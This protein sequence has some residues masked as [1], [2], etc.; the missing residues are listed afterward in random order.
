LKEKVLGVDWERS[1]ADSANIQ[2]NVDVNFSAIHL[3]IY[4]QE[5]PSSFSM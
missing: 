4:I 2:L 1:Q 3:H 5:I